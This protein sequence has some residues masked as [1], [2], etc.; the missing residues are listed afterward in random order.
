MRVLNRRFFTQF[1]VK[2]IF[3]E[4]DRHLPRFVQEC[5]QVPQTL[6]KIRVDFVA[7]RECDEN[8]DEKDE[9]TD[10][11]V[12]YDKR[13][14]RVLVRD[15]DEEHAECACLEEEK[16]KH[17]LKDEVELQQVGVDDVVRSC[18]ESKAF[19]FQLPTDEQYVDYRQG[20]QVK[21]EEDEEVKVEVGA[22]ERCR[23]CHVVKIEFGR[24]KIENQK[25]HGHV[26][27]VLHEFEHFEEHDAV[28]VVVGDR[29]QWYRH[30]QADEGR[31]QYIRL[32]L[33]L[34]QIVG[35]RDDQ[36]D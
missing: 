23:R 1:Q 24:K 4:I 2:K 11:P 28:F 5:Q 8:Y 32:C 10:K 36:V 29:L 17:E 6:T 7:L 27:E 35:R 15:E 25:R 18:V 21:I 22:V 34:V 14:V 31:L 26:E 33:E 3:I 19:A 9:V 13:A 12:G 16:P 30:Q 20:W